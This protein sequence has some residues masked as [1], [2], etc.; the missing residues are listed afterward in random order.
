MLDVVLTQRTISSV[1][2]L[3]HHG[4][5]PKDDTTRMLDV[6]LTQRTISSVAVLRHRGNCPKEDTTRMLDVVL[7][8]R[9]ISSVAVLRHHGNHKNVRC[10]SHP[11]YYFVSFCVT[12]PRKLS[13]EDT[14]RMLDVVLTQRTISS[15]AV[16]RHHGNFPKD[17]T[18]RM[19]DVVLTQRTI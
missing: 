14:I 2:V 7:T 12:T 18:T 1:A 9:T 16:L 15:V 13:K 10:G 8:Q 11:T 19:L 6:V 3:R 4:N 5:C 17:D